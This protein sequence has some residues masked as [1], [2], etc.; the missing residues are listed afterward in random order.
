MTTRT[1]LSLCGILAASTLLLAGCG[2]GKSEEKSPEPHAKRNPLETT[3]SESLLKQIKIG[4]P[5]WAS[6]AGTFSVAAHIEADAS[7]LA[8]VGS[9]VTGRITDLQVMEG[10]YV[11]RGQTLATI[12]STE[13][14]DAQF[15]FIKAYSQEQ[16]SKKSAERA[17]QLLTA[18]VIGSAELQRREA[19]V[20]QAGAE[21]AS[22]RQQLRVF[23]MSDEAVRKLETTRTLNSEY[24]VIAS[25]D[26]TV[27]E[28]KVAIGQIVQPAELAFTVSD[29]S[30]V[31]LVAD[32]PEQNS[33]D[34]AVGK[35]VEAEIPAL[36]GDN[37]TGKLSFVSS[38]VNPETRTVRTRMNLP[39]PR[40]RYKPAMLANM[41]LKSSAEKRRVIPVTSIVRE[42]NQDHVFVQ[43]AGDTFVLRPVTLGMEFEDRRVLTDGVKPGEKIIIDGA[44]HVN[45]ERKRAALQGGD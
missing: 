12:H 38:I 29:L 25:I 41:V 23:G 28:R 16:L 39:N 30:S 27:L 32:V 31:W 4:E 44:F 36:P 7:R 40:G 2:A 18:D 33:A 21:V 8:R 13:L 42:D 6:V 1:A 15:A 11:K 3:V 45:N 35:L 24:Q 19:E 17:K 22:L 26:G 37:I 20:L 10:D 34:V 5:Q 14:S 43:T 9:P